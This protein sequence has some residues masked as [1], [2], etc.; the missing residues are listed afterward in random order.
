MHDLLLMLEPFCHLDKLIFVI[1]CLVSILCKVNV[2]PFSCLCIIIIGCSK[3]FNCMGIVDK[4][5]KLGNVE[6]VLNPEIFKYIFITV[7]VIQCMFK[8]CKSFRGV[9]RVLSQIEK[10]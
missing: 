2:K 4:K 6:V 10:I 8:S 7:E 1:R 3:K 9:D 5:M